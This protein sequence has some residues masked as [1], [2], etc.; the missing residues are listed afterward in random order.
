LRPE[1]FQGRDIGP[2]ELIPQGGD[3]HTN[4]RCRGNGSRLRKCMRPCVF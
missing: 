2:F 4:Q 3:F 1:W